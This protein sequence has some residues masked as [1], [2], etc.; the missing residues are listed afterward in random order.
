MGRQAGAQA[1]GKVGACPAWPL[2]GEVLGCLSP[3]LL[4][5]HFLSHKLRKYTG[6][7][8]PLGRQLNLFS[9]AIRLSF[10]GRSTA[11][12]KKLQSGSYPP[13]SWSHMLPST[14]VHPTVFP[15]TALFAKLAQALRKD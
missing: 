12:S 9:G 1:E 15:T 5:S 8:M 10:Q 7:T 11:P 2:M 14:P 3:T 6:R 4:E 13:A